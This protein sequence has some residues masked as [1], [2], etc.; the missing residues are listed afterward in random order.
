MKKKLTTSQEGPDQDQSIV[1]FQLIHV[2][3]R[4]KLLNAATYANVKKQFGTAITEGQVSS[5][6]L[7]RFWFEL[8]K[9]T[10]RPKKALPELSSFFPKVEKGELSAT[11][12]CKI[13]KISRSTY[14]RRYREW[15]AEH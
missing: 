7:D 14:Y 10:G 6:F 12:V 2:L 3:Y 11:D 15:L 8:T 13:L 5:D 9:H 1:A 4:S